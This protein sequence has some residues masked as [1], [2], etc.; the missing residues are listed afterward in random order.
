VPENGKL[1]VKIRFR[2]RDRGERRARHAPVLARQRLYVNPANGKVYVAE[3]DCGVM[4]A[5]NQLVE[6]DP[7]TGASGSWTCRWAPRTCAST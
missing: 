2:Q 4:K 6:L 1:V 7:A 5:V 3:G